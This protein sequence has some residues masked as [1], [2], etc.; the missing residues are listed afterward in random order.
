MDFEICIRAVGE[1]LRAAGTEVGKSGNELF[2]R[3]GGR[4]PEMDGGG[5]RLF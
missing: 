4:L 3:R 1:K 2:R 5:E